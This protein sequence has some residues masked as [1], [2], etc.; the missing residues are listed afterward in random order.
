MLRVTAPAKVNLQ[1]SVGPAGSDGYHALTSVFHTLEL[2]DE[3]TLTPSDELNMTCDVDLG[4]PARDNLAFK[5][6]AAFGAAVGFEPRVSISVRK[7]IP[8]GA[9]LGGGSSDAAAVI[10]GLTRLWGIDPA[11]E[12]RIA[13]AQ[14][15]GADVAFFLVSGGAALM[16]GRG[17]VVARELMALSGVP[18][19]LVRPQLG[20]STAAA[21]AQFDRVP[22]PGVGPD[23]AIAALESSDPAALA[24]A[25]SNNLAPAAIA[26]APVVGE[27]L[28][29]VRCCEGVAGA[30]V[31]GSGSAVFA[32]CE[33]PGHARDIA[34]QAANRGWWGLA[35]ALGACG[36]SINDSKG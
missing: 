33:T 25:I 3:V 31:S 34:S 20:V 19:A 13:V 29:W 7:H 22:A 27:V 24:R 35:T 11:D 14:R 28:A 23:D 30:E 2:A 10:A 6:A 32:L 9:G 17:D 4:I 21:Y 16:T 12:R 8:H 18:V 1:L 36:V 15:L 26:V 5:A